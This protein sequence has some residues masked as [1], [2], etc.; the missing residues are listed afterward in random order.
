MKKITITLM[1]GALIFTMTACGN[2]AGAGGQ[3]TGQ[4]ES[5][6]ESTQESTAPTVESGATDPGTFGG[7]EG[8]SAEMTQVRD[9]VVAEIGDDYWPNTP[10]PAD[11]LEVRYNITADMYDDYMGEIPMISTNVDTLLIIK[12]KSDKVEDVEQ[13]LLDYYDYQVSEALQYPMNLEKI[14]AA[15]VH[16]I[17]NYVCFVMLGGSAIDEGDTDARIQ[18][19]QE[20]NEQVIEIISQ[21]LQHE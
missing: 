19:C 12:A 3:S 21:L 11:L 15:K 2:N 17:G 13:L 8:W 10:L 18:A 6:Q 16:R 7:E 5:T 14:Q 9:A 1:L 4:P 20:Q